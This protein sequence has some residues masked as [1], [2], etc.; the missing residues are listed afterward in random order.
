MSTLLTELAGE[1]YHQVE[2]MGPFGLIE[3]RIR[4]LDP[5]RAS[6]VMLL[7]A[8]L[9]A[10]LAAAAEGSTEERWRR[11][12]EAGIALS[13]ARVLQLQLAAQ[14][15]LL[16]PGSPGAEAN[17]RGAATAEQAAT[18][19]LTLL[20]ADRRPQAEEKEKERA[21]RAQDRLLA[22]CVCGVRRKGETEWSPV[23][24]VLNEP[25]QDPHKGLL[26]VRSLNLFTRRALIEAVWRPLSEVAERL[27]TFRGPLSGGEGAEGEAGQDGE[28][29]R[30]DA[31][32]PAE[33]ACG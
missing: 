16:P 12:T 32:D 3:W 24:L 21:A 20:R 1:L 27:A 30:V 23:G 25:E 2:V 28:A 11:E 33:A 19:A 17:R 5:I 14:H 6:E 22:A 7:D 26:Y 13:Q 10:V 18:R 8:V 4:Q 29:L 31:L 9:A 15:P